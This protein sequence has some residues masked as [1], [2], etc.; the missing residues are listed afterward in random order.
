MAALRRLNKEF[1]DIC[2]APPEGCVCELVDDNLRAW[3]AHVQGP[4]DTPYANG[5]FHVQLDFPERYP[6]EAPK[7]KFT[8]PVYHVNVKSDG[9]EICMDMLT[10]WA[11]T[12]KIAQLLP[13][14]REML[15]NPN[16]SHPLE[17]TLAEEF[18]NNRA[19][20]DREAAAATRRHAR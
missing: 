15:A 13:A 9:S 3:R 1:Q 2:K 7:A 4:E 16:P 6:F 10:S 14:L 19:K 17:D 18:V 8:H 20:Y 12:I 11:P 5:T